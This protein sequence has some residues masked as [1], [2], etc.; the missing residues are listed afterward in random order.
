MDLEIP[1][2]MPATAPTGLFRGAMTLPLPALNDEEG[3]RVDPSLPPVVDA[4]VHLFPDRVFDAVW[5]WFDQHGWPIRYKLHTPEV[6]RFLLSR[7]V[8]RI[9]ALHYAHK[10]GIAREMNAYMAGVVAGEPR[11]TGLAT[12]MPGEPGARAILDEAFA[13]GLAGVKLHCHVQ[14]FAPD[15]D[16]LA[17]V[18][19]ACVAHDLPLVM[20]AGREP[21][22][23]AYRCDPHALCSAART[24]AVLRA[25]P[26]LRLSVPHLGA[27][28]IE[29]YGRLL[30]RYDNLWLDTTMVVGG[31]FDGVD[32]WPLTVAR[33]D[34]IMYGTDFP[35]LPY[36][37]DRELK[38]FG[39]VRD[40][41]VLARL[42]G[43][44]ARDFFRLPEATP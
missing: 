27:D 3:P 9:V 42:V 1:G 43:G 18:Y 32:G 41:E 30:E 16:A 4:H 12:V 35:N 29:G 8:S 34:R 33:S 14:C 25:Y 10:P 7:G 23:A 37:W 5:R 36:A 13:A 26:K 11:V 24:E 28:E 44:T 31:Y 2:C 40:E 15:D 20:H 21:K 6:V 22:S 17:E 38:R 19:E 39:S